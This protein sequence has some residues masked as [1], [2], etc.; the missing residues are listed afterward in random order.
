MESRTATKTGGRHDLDDEALGNYL[1]RSG[2]MPGLKLPLVTTKIGYGQSNPT[3][4]VDDAAGTRFILRKKP[5]GNAISPVAHQIDREFRV[6]KALGS[7]AGFPVPGAYTLCMD[8]SVIGSHFYTMEFVKGRI[9]TDVDMKELSP[10][11]RR[12]AWFSA[13]ETL[14]WLHSLDPDAIGLEGYGKKHGFYA[15]HCNTW[16]RIE[17]QQAAVKNPDSGQALGRAHENYDEVMDYIRANLPGERSAI[18]HGDFKFDNLVR[19]PGGIYVPIPN[20]HAPD[21]ASYR[22]QGHSHH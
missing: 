9:I 16:S 6:L 12:K 22:A 20:Q 19:E 2:T 8:N 4:F 1:I 11:D 14:A 17:A 7:V 13:V 10:A 15:R 3:Y 18:V 21:F 5:Q